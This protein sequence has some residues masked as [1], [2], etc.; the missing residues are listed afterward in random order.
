MDG[1]SCK[2]YAE[3]V[4]GTI[5]AAAT[6]ITITTSSITTNT[7]ITS[8]MDLSMYFSSTGVQLDVIF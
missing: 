7:A 5:S 2:I 8:T 3:C 6:T 1:V 4:L